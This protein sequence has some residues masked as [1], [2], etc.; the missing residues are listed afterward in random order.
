MNQILSDQY[1]FRSQLVDEL[2][3]DLVGPREPH[4]VLTDAPLSWYATGVLWPAAAGSI[5]PERQTDEAADYDELAPPD[6]GVSLANA[7]YPSSMA[8]TFAV[9]TTRTDRIVITVSAGRYVPVEDPEQV[10]MLDDTDDTDDT[11]HGGAVPETRS[12]RDIPDRW[13][14]IPVLGP[15]VEIGVGELHDRRIA[16]EPGLELFVRV[17]PADPDGLASVT[18]ALVNR[19]KTS[20][21]LRDSD[22]YFQSRIEVAGP[23]DAPVFSARR[24]APGELANEELASYRL[25]YRHAATFAVGHGCSATWDDVDPDDPSHATGVRSTFVPFYDLPIS[26]SN[27]DLPTDTL[28]MLG[29][30]EG[31]RSQVL[32]GFRELEAEYRRWITNLSDSVAQLDEDLRD[33]A[34]QNLAECAVAADRI[35]AGITLLER[36]DTAWEAFV[37]ANRAMLTQR[38]RTVWI[39]RER[40]D[41]GPEEDG[42]HRWRPFQIAF[43]LMCLPGIAD[44]EHPDRDVADLL[45]FPTGGGKTE[46]YLGLIAFSILHRRLRNPES[47]GG[48]TALMRY[49]LR[50][51]TIQQFERASL[52]IAALELLR[53]DEPR[54]GSEP[55]GIGLWVGGDAT[56]NTLTNAK[57]AL[58]S[59]SSGG[60]PPNTGNPVQIHACPWCGA[61]LSPSDYWVDSGKTRMIV[62]CPA[63]AC[64]FSRDNTGS[65]PLAQRGLPVYIIDEEVYRYRPSL[66]IATVDKFAGLPWRERSADLFNVGNNPPPELI[67]QDELHLISGPLGT[68]TG[69]YETAIDHLC[70][71]DGRRPKVVASTATIRRA[72]A[73]GE[74][75]FNR[76]VKQFPPPGLDA[77]DSFF[78]REANPED[79]GTRR[80]V[81]V[82]AAGA[83]HATLMIRVYASLL[84]AALSLPADAA[85]KD[86]YWTLVGYFNSLRVLGGAR[87]QV[88][89]DVGDRIALLAQGGQERARDQV[90]ELTSRESSSRIPAYLSQM[91]VEYPDVDAIDVILATNMISVGVDINRL[92]LMAVMGQPPSTS[93]YIQATSRVGR[94][95]PGLVVAVYNAH[96]SRDRS[97]YESFIGYHNTLYQQVE[98]TSVTPFS[99]RARDRA[100][101]A[102][103]VGLARALFEHYRPNNGASA[104]KTHRGDLDLIRDVIRR[105]VEDVEPTETDATMRE[106]DRFIDKWAELAQRHS[107]LRYGHPFDTEGTLLTE[108]DTLDLDP[109]G[110]EPTLWSMRDVDLTSHLYL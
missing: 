87:M 110:A 102:V 41:P 73:Q 93:E 88:Q 57:K 30:A 47:G 29:I 7:R 51:L 77:R 18:A 56:P 62:E 46:A 17:R 69:L 95:H 38:A 39:Q 65:F 108:A 32:S 27:P 66:L 5:G 49:T 98:A 99:P 100:I 6:P 59:M 15:T 25:L 9:D 31:A 90:I 12:R 104:I 40:P 42:S 14:R 36:D 80:Y 78:S 64:E 82:M 33:A 92:G 1:G 109:D 11:V 81:G 61:R 13:R 21:G 97:H 4:E 26:D 43:I 67:V 86:P 48:L 24:R 55:I 68:L 37:L 74:A 10:K 35:A 45:W 52:L 71:T 107:N 84:Q 22:S 89:D 63:K 101:H 85:T 103:V 8:I 79:R 54:L 2:E 53:R 83:S 50:L 94:A 91:A 34:D 105:R 20:G 70:T 23:D 19:R 75:L 72:G 76:T 106:V 3:L 60:E 28:E 16:V 44:A 58:A 96:R